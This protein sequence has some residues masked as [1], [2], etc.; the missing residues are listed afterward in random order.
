MK[1]TL[2]YAVICF[3]IILA[4]VLIFPKKKIANYPSSGTDIVA[5]GDSLVQGVGSNSGG[6]FVSILSKKIG[7]PIV[8]LG[9]SG[10]TTRDGLARINDLDNYKPKVVIVLFGGNDYLKKI[11]IDQTQINLIK[12]IRNIQARGAVVILL[13]VRGGLLSDPFDSMFEDISKTMKTAYVSN[14]LKGLILNSNYMSDA[15]HPN[16][17]GYAIIAEKIY[18]TLSRLVK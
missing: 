7:Q 3:V 14:V 6:D 18:P 16:N 11:P 9:H 10:D 15:V 2:Y 13:G 8:N 5:F 4:I 12:I 17:A 1:K